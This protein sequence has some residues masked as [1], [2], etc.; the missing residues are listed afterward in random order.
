MLYNLPVRKRQ[1]VLFREKCHQ[2]KKV[3]PT[4]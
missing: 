2:W 3:L 4:V 1:S